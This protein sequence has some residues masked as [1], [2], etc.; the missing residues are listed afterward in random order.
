MSTASCTAERLA[1]VLGRL[2]HFVEEGATDGFA[3]AVARG[4]E[5][6]AE[7]YYGHMSHHRRVDADTLWPLA[8]ISKLYTA[9]TVMAL[10][11]RGELTL[12]MPVHTLLPH[13][14]R[15]ARKD[16][17][18]RHLLTHTSGLARMSSSDLERLLI[19]QASLSQ[20]LV[21]S[22]TYPLLFPPGNAFNY[23]DYGYILAAALAE[24][25]T[26]RCFPDLLK[27]L[28]LHPAAL[29]DTYLPPPPNVY[30]RVAY[31]G[32]VPAEGT[33]GAMYNSPHFRGL[34]HP[35]FGV[36]ATVRDLVRFGLL[37]TPSSS[38][39]ILSGASVRAMTTDQTGGNAIGH[40]LPLYPAQQQPWGL[41]FS[42][43][44]AMGNGFE[45]MASPK[46]F[47]HV[48]ASG[49][50]LLVDP[51]VDIII[52]FVSNRFVGTAV[53]PFIQ[54]LSTVVGMVL[55]ALT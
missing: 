8:C 31:V 50:I 48:G 6:V 13:F 2:R 52:A 36:V 4:H 45:D 11:E 32:G 16:I 28:V 7:C 23:T 35:A 44:G 19:Q 54:R 25:A 33:A 30:D 29:H 24:A 27:A 22:D 43:R 39:R 26:G 1:P 53:E 17:R 38:T 55:A 15:D 20:H 10:V 51:T 3:L 12:S 40:V 18:L 5:I 41:G 9:T 47:D 34:A 14:A 37:F 42:I 49:S 46:T 21:D